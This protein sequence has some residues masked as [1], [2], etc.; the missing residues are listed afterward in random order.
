MKKTEKTTQ[1]RLFH[2]RDAANNIAQFLKDVDFNAFS[3]NREKFAATLYE[4]QIIGE[5]CYRIDKTYKAQHPQIEWAKI[6]R[7]RH[8]IVH[9]YDAVDE[10][11]IWRI[12]T[13]YVPQLLT[14]IAPLIDTLN[15][16]K[17]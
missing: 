17:S 12:A 1:L 10:Q 7:T 13:T 4:I 9:D 11:T 8:I 5:A 15:M 3:A 16:I 14:D 6:E 2:M